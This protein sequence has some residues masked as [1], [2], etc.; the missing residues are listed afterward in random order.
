M[1]KLGER[2]KDTITGFQGIVTARCSYL[3]GCEQLLIQS[4]KLDK[5]GKVIKGEWIDEPQLVVLEEPIEP[6]KK[7][8]KEKPGGGFRN[9]P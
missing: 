9:H 7:V 4:Q 3:N 2:V 8:K 5:D 6:I 1:T